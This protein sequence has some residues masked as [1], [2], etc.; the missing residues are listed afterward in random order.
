[1]PLPTLCVHEQYS[2]GGVT[3]QL[4]G[5][6]PSLPPCRRGTSGCCLATA[7]PL[8]AGVIHRPGTGVARFKGGTANVGYRSCWAALTSPGG[9]LGGAHRANACFTT[10]ATV[11]FVMPRVLQ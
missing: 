11:S 3:R 8:A 9:G 6:S 5:W 2:Q 10:S 7:G 1:S 4:T